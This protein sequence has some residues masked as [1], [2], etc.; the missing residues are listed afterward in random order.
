MH[1]IKRYGWAI[2]WFG[3]SLARR[4]LTVLILASFLGTTGTIATAT[5]TD[6][7]VSSD[8]SN[9]TGTAADTDTDTDTDTDDDTDKDTAPEDTGPIIFGNTAGELANE[10]GG[11]AC[12]GSCASTPVPYVAGWM[13]LCLA[14]ILRSRR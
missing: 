5:T 13:V 9:D 11:S 3:G 12:S 2:A 4:W 1:F 8:T 14:L 10:K 6:T 7:S